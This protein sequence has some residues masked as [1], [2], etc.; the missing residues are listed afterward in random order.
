M[1]IVICALTA[2]CVLGTLYLSVFAMNTLLNWSNT[3]GQNA[4]FVWRILIFVAILLLAV[5]RMISSR[6]KSHDVSSQDSANGP[7]PNCG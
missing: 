1:R 5:P 6:F 3:L 2:T 7:N 4:I